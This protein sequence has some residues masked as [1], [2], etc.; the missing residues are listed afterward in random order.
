MDGNE[1]D[2]R[3]EHKCEPNEEVQ[4]EKLDSLGVLSWQGLTGPEDPL[5]KEIC[6]TRGYTYTDMVY[7][8]PEKLPEYE[9]KII[10]FFRE[11]IH[12]D[13]EIRYCI[14]GS[15]Y[16]DIRDEDDRWIRVSCGPGDMI[17]LPEGMYHRFTCD[18]K[19]YGQF[20]VNRTHMHVF[21]F[22]FAIAFAS[23][24]PL[25]SLY[26]RLIVFIFN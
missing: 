3:E 19:N 1:A 13:E 21:V 16:F 5:L 8:C 20:M 15:G 7:V 23:F 10:N 4:I 24:N 26:N 18:T 14:D 2:Q 25:I 11:H 6:T 9:K 17:I 22:T 12:Y